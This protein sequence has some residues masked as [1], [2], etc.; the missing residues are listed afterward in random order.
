MFPDWRANIEHE[1]AENN[2]VMV[3]L[4]GPGTH[5][6]EFHG[7]R[8]TGKPINIRSVDLYRIENGIITGYWDVVNQ[9]NLLTQIGLLLSEDGNKEFKDANVV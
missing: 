8:P 6:G 4:N 7:V 2:Q 1:I 9:L 5:K 3:F